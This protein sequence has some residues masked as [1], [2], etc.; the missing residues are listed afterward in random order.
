MRDAKS[1]LLDTSV[2]Y[3]FCDAHEIPALKAYLGGIARITREVRRELAV[4]PL[5]GIHRD[6]SVLQ[7]P[8]WPKKTGQIPEPMLGD[9][10]R[11]KDE[12]R[13]EEARFRG[14]DVS[15]IPGYKHAG[16]VTTVLMAEHLRADLV[17]IDDTF[18]KHLAIA[19]RVARVSTAQLCL[20]M[21]VESALDE[22]R[23]FAVFDLS[24]PPGVGKPRYEQALQEA[25]AQMRA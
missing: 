19:R 5:D 18:G 10:N 12:A 8:P 15:T 4:A 23:G 21:V 2:F 7:T 13:L 25:R 24:T 11:L 20:Q 22:G 1:V 6:L 3:R 17:V 9:A 14:V 16:E